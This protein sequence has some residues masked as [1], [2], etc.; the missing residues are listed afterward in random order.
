[1]ALE[2]M[3]QTAVANRMQTPETDITQT[4]S[5][6]IA[7]KHR[8]QRTGQA[9][10]IKQTGKQSSDREVHNWGGNSMKTTQQRADTN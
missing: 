5:A 3:S 4:N 8:E 1:M 9:S 7:V 10:S 2:V 6:F